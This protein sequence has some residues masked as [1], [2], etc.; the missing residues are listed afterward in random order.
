MGSSVTTGHDAPDK[1]SEVPA[2]GEHVKGSGDQNI[3]ELLILIKSNSSKTLCILKTAK[4]KRCTLNTQGVSRGG[5]GGRSFLSQLQLLICNRGAESDP[6]AQEAAGTV[7]PSQSSPA[8]R[9]GRLR[10]LGPRST[11]TNGTPGK[12]LPLP[13]PRLSTW[14]QKAAPRSASCMRRKREHAG[15][16]CLHGPG[17]GKGRGARQSSRLPAALTCPEPARRW[18]LLESERRVQAWG[19]AAGRRR[20]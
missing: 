11:P 2:T 15:G 9:A 3:C 7:S 19:P 16:C 17:P 18:G 4:N 1:S 14:A 20:A 12:P 6:P 8:W 5:G 10:A 13:A